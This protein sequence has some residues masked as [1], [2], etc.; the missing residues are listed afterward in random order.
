[1]N[2]L[3]SLVSVILLM[4]AA[5]S[6]ASADELLDNTKAAYHK[7]RQENQQREA[8]FRQTEAELKAHKQ[9]LQQQIAALQAESDRLT[10]IFSQNEKQLADKEQALHLATGSLGE[11]FGV[12]RQVA[13]ELQVEMQQSVASIGKA[14]DMALINDIVAAKTLPSAQQLH[15]L[16]RVLS[17]QIDASGQAETVAVNHIGG[18]GVHAELPATRLGSLGLLGDSGYLKWDGA[19]QTAADYLRQ[20]EQAPTSSAVLTG[21]SQPFAIDPS[22]GTLLEQLGNEPGLSERFAQGG[23][24]GKVIAGLLLVGILIGVVR[25]LSLLQVQARIRAQLKQPQQP[26]NNPLGRVLQV[27]REDKTLNVEALEL[28]LLESIVDE[29]QQLERGLS[30]IKLFAA[31]APML[32]L[33]GTVTGMIETFQTITQFGNADPRVM[34]GGISM[35]LVTTVLGLIAAMPLLLLHNI[36]SSQAGNISAVIEKQGIGLVAERA[37]QQL[38]AAA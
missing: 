38:E 27:Y 6:S 10:D 8:G 4:I 26:G 21:S 22:R 3:K 12:V 29:Q 23:P 18:D 35:A 2:K 14:Q 11:L 24:V 19:T 7:Q 25:G 1:M 13:K 37:E 5:F 16:W 32:G 20:P 34:A 17:D 28:R 30:L 31:L 36:L 33:L 15:G 9:A